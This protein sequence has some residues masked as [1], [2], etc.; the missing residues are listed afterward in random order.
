[1]MCRNYT[2][3]C[4]ALMLALA[5]SLPV[6]AL[7]ESPISTAHDVDAHFEVAS[8]DFGGGVVQLHSRKDGA[9]GETHAVHSFD[10]EAKSY[11]PVFTGA[12]APDL[13]P[14]DSLGFNLEPID[15]NS[16]IAPLA[17]HTCKKHGYPLLEW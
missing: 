8:K 16:D 7:A 12:S 13:F 3:R 4:L 15:E 17:Q 11:A 2:K 14:M 10:C 1:M 6:A 5:V 9:D